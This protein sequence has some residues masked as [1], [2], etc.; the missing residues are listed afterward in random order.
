MLTEFIDRARNDHG[1][2]QKE[3]GL[4]LAEKAYNV[5]SNWK[6]V[7]DKGIPID[8]I[9]PF[10]EVAKMSH[11]ELIDLIATRLDEENGKQSTIDVKA[12]LLL[13]EFISAPSTENKVMQEILEEE[14][15]RIG[16][17]MDLFSDP[18]NKK[19]L[20]ACIAD[21]IQDEA[22]ECAE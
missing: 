2:S 3:I 4:T 20:R 11:E 22:K 13:I 12:L 17:R 15:K 19:K 1:I 18:E 6:K 10:A 16:W 7:G 9:I 5:I 14:K 8:Q 21:I